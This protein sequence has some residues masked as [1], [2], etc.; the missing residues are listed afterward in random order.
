MQLISWA[1]RTLNP[2][3]VDGCSGS[4]Q[5]MRVGTQQS[6]GICHMAR[7]LYVSLSVGGQ[8]IA[9]RDVHSSEQSPSEKKEGGANSL[10]H[11]L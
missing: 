1:F 7:K 4:S 5:G 9:E 10:V 11:L 3:C 6:H 2:C 8:R